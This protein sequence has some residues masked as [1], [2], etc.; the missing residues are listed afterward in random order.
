MKYY[1]T[2]ADGSLVPV[3]AEGGLRFVETLTADT[4]LTVADSGKL[5]LLDAIG[6]EILLPTELVAGV[7]F[8]FMLIAATATSNWTIVSGTDVIEGYA[9]VN[10]ATILASNENTIS[11]VATKGIAGDTVKVVCDG[12]SWHA[13]GV[14][15][16]A[17]TITFTAPA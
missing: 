12:T 3:E 7:E 1:K 4:T 13:T 9:A 10:Y 17:A 8:E 11:F 14:A 16:V 2:A 15:S 5:Y 6:E